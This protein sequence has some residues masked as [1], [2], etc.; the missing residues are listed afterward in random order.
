MEFLRFLSSYRTDFWNT[1]FSVVTLFGEATI[2]VAPLV[3]LFLCVDKKAAYRAAF[4]YY[5][6]A[7]LLNNIKLLLKIPRPWIIDQSFEPVEGAKTTATG[8]SF[9]SGHSQ[10][11]SSIYGSLALFIKK[12]WAKAALAVLTA[13]VAFSRLFIGVHTLADVVVGLLIGSASAILFSMIRIDEKG[14]PVLSVILGI[15]VAFSAANGFIAWHA[16]GEV[17]ANTHDIM[18]VSGSG[19][20]LAL[21]YFLENRYIRFDEKRG[22]WIYHAV[23]LFVGLGGTAAI[24]GALK[25]VL[26]TSAPMNFIRYFAAIS[27][28]M[29]IFP[30]LIKL[31]QNYADM[32]TAKAEGITAEEQ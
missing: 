15:L 24:R 14:R 23:K 16:G 26:G 6:S 30:W 8:Y 19:L 22:S 2:L 5:F 20:A 21:G 10:S 32:K 29:I 9:P 1:V 27:W 31:N 11:A 13:A 3:V 17:A 7:L 25:A 12:R 4:A 18:T 28:I